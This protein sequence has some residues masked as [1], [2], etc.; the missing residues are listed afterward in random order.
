MTQPLIKPDD[1]YDMILTV[2]KDYGVHI[3]WNANDPLW[4]HAVDGCKWHFAFTAIMNEICQKFQ[5][6]HGKVSDE[7][8]KRILG[9][10]EEDYVMYLHDLR[11]QPDCQQE[12]S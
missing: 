1:K 12:G 6:H 10:N 5:R 2:D 8:F 7:E 9:M 11:Q 3:I 4:V